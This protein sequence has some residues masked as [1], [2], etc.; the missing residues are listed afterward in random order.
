MLG[1]RRPSGIDLNGL[2]GGSGAQIWDL[3]RDLI[4]ELH[5]SRLIEVADRR[6][7]PTLAGL[8]V[9]EALACRFDLAEP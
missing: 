9:A 7:L 6:L 4:T 5:Q 2:P 8:A 1:L 3:N